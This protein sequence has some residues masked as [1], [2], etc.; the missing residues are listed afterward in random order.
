MARGLPQARA[1]PY[2]HSGKG[3]YRFLGWGRDRRYARSDG[4]H[5]GAFW[6][7]RPFGSASGDR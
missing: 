3:R 2:L 5:L 4:K 6:R 1:A 7:A